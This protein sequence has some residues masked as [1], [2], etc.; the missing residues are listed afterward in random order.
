MDWAIILAGG[1]GTRFWPL[2]SPHHPKQLL[3]LAGPVPTAVAAL[4]AVEPLVSRERVLVVT[5]A[6]LAQPLGTA[7]GLPVAQVLVEPRAASTAPALAWATC[8]IQA[9]DPEA[10]ILSMHADWYLADP[11]GFRRAADAALV[12][13]RTHDALLTVGIVPTRAETG[14]GYILPGERIAGGLRRVTRFQE[15]PDR[16]GAE[17]LIAAGALWNSG[18]FAWTARRFLAELSEHAPEL[19]ES[20]SRLDPEHPADFFAAVTPVA[21]DHAVFER[22]SR[23]LTL[24]GDFGWDDVGSWDALTRLRQADQR[25]NVLEGP[26]YLDDSTGIVGWSDGTPIVVSGVHDVIVVHANNRVL[27]MDR[28]RA[29]DLKRVLD[30][31]PSRVRDLP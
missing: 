14:Y 7:L 8:L 25:G 18:L 26:V 12:A 2:S 1:S 28:T 17:A 13:A 31:L 6:G 5:G 3:P 16:P 19:A 10:T 4:A 24:P 15:K 30:Q 21:V 11:A 22:S 23:V 9:R 20:L 27:V 29:A